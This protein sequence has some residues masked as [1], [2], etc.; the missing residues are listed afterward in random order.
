M[1]G[2]LSLRNRARA[3]LANILLGVLTVLLAAVVALA[4]P[5]HA[6]DPED[7][8][9]LRAADADVSITGR[10][11]RIPASAG[12]FNGDGFDDLIVGSTTGVDNQAGQ[13]HVVLGRPEADALDLD[14]PDV[15]KISG[16]AP[17]ADATAVA[18]GKDVNGDG[19]D[20]IVI[21][22]Q[23]AGNNGSQSDLSAPGAAY[24]VFGSSAPHDIDLSTLDGTSSS[25]FRVDGRAGDRL[26]ISVTLIPD[27]TSDGRA[28][29]G[30]TGAYPRR[31]GLVVY[32]RATT[33]PVSTAGFG[34]TGTAGIEILSTPDGVGSDG[35]PI[36]WID[37]TPDING[38]GRPEVLELRSD[39][40]VVIWGRSRGGQVP[41]GPP[42]AD[43]PW[44]VQIRVGGRVTAIA[45]IGDLDNDGR[46]DFLI[47]APETSPMGRTNAGS[48][49]LLFGQSGT[50]VVEIPDVGDAEG[51][52]LSR[53]I[54]ANAR[55]TD[56][57]LG[58]AIDGT[59]DV[60]GDGRPDLVASAPQADNDG[61]SSGSAYVVFGDP[62][63]TRIDLRDFDGTQPNGYRVDG[64]GQNNQL[65]DKVSSAG[66]FN[67]DGV[68]DVAILSDPLGLSQSIGI[69]Y[70]FGP[71]RLSVRRLAFPRT[72][73]GSDATETLTVT[74]GSK[75]AALD[76]T[77]LAL[78]GDGSGR[79][80]IA[81]EDCVASAIAVGGSC[82]V[83]VTFNPVQAGAAQATLTIAHG[84]A[85]GPKEVELTATGTTLEA[86]PLDINFGSAVAGSQSDPVAV[87]IT[88]RASLAATISSA[89]ITG[90]NAASFAADASDCTSDTVALGGSCS[91]SVV[92]TPTVGGGQ[93]TATL[94]IVDDTASSPTQVALSGVATSPQVQLSR[95]RIDFGDQR[96]GTDS[97]RQTVRLENH[98]DAA[99]IVS[100][101]QI[102][103]SGQPDFWLEAQGCT[104]A[105]I[106]VDGSCDAHVRF[107][108]RSAGAKSGQLRFVN[109]SPDSPHLTSLTGTGT[110]PVVQMSRPQMSL[111][112][113]RIGR[114]ST[115]ESVTL[116]NTGTAALSVASVRLSGADAGQFAIASQSCQIA[117]IPPK[118][119]CTIAVY[120]EPTSGGPKAAQIEISSDATTAP[121]VMLTAA[122]IN[123]L[124]TV[125][126]TVLN[127]GG[128]FAGTPSTAQI[129]I[130]NIGTDAL[131]VDAPEVQGAE[132]A[133]FSIISETCTE[134]LVAIGAHCEFD[135]RFLPRTPG[136]YQAAL[137]VGVDSPQGV[138]AVTLLGSGNPVLA[139]DRDGDGVP[140][141]GDGCPDLHAD[142]HDPD[143]DGCP[144]PFARLGS[145][146]STTMVNG[147]IVTL[148]VAA[149]ESSKIE[150]RCELRCPKLQTKAIT[151]AG[152]ATRGDTD[153]A[154]VIRANLRKR[155][156][157]GVLVTRAGAF[158][159]YHQLSVTATR[160]KK[161]LRCTLPGSKRPIS[162]SKCAQASPR[163]LVDP[164]GDG[165]RTSL[166]ACP[167][168]DPGGLDFDGD[169]CIGPLPLVDAEAPR[170]GAHVGRGADRLKL[171]YLRVKVGPRVSATLYRCVAKRCT[172]M[173]NRHSNRTR[174][175]L[176]FTQLGTR[177]LAGATVA[178]GTRLEIALT[179]Q[180]RFGQRHSFAVLRSGRKVTAQRSVKCLRPASTNTEVPCK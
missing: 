86:G 84:A 130:E 120:G 128:Q 88:N 165:I 126:P 81:G 69:Y 80:R 122:G 45:R 36:R 17:L 131:R 145:N 153:I 53:I 61:L 9:P 148:G 30:V 100:A 133:A 64:T 127:F 24:V 3:E 101:V 62:G 146:V 66:D 85:G 138:I 93:K 2:W 176:E 63:A 140:D 52:R 171:T 42:T 166:D 152:N 135:I 112:D 28:E 97:P 155:S 170:L 40:A 125:T 149:P 12:D 58:S 10:E 91:V 77:G 76:I 50:P 180:G 177:K 118:G 132:A 143:G 34:P 124:A 172:L 6:A 44:G 167:D 134:H 164:D 14:D 94:E 89:S 151:V 1:V 78:S 16:A 8:G 161:T 35:N 123:P 105:P 99:L 162:N 142:A 71:I 46:G 104:A 73:L 21:G 23:N 107:G 74:N 57:R 174:A 59:G 90:A 110:A 13:A 109:S 15:I 119:F 11:A 55:A 4:P 169:G 72:L 51:Q 96:S 116:T 108:P 33:L 136:A 26:G 113:V 48:A 139:P 121:A 168:S 7:G 115:E 137:R 22:A 54:G 82:S 68:N 19:Y 178:I 98:G 173:Q 47:S 156:V 147:T 106:P 25:G 163:E 144:G 32:G 79:F 95:G 70:G 83:E 31:R 18:G 158:G 157:V 39:G 103:S 37:W 154:G 49:W 29:I 92:F 67:G 111:G 43:D 160:V 38:D 114:R 117:P 102:T 150:L 159:D 129:T 75:V 27:M 179:S 175:L 41:S 56:N 5:A 87:T 20:D 65:G 60:N 141:A